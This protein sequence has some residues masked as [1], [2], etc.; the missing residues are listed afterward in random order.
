MRAQK[1]GT[2]INISSRAGV[3][4]ARREGRLTPYG[5][6]KTGVIQYT[7]FL[8][9]DVGPDSIRVNCIAPGTIA[10]ARILKT[11][12]ERGISTDVDL[13]DIPLRRFGS[14]EDVAGVV[15]FFASDLSAFVTGQCL[16]VCGGTV[17]TPS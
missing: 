1:G 12:Q 3:D 16:S 5:I 11:A 6:A 14:T 8:A 17:L 15:Q 2:I 10:T 4:P 9:H 7:R 13:G